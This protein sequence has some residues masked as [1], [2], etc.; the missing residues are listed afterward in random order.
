MT[1][2]TSG[3]AAQDNPQTTITGNGAWQFVKSENKLAQSDATVLQVHVR[4]RSSAQALTFYVD[5]AIAIQEATIG[6][7]ADGTTSGWLWTGTPNAS[8]SRGPAQ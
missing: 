3:A 5:D 6:G 2:R 1:I 8:T 4:T 7:Y